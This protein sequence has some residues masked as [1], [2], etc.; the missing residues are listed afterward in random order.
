[1]EN[2]ND[3]EKYT[4]AAAGAL[5]H[6]Q[7]IQNTRFGG[8]GGSDAGLLLRIGRNGMSA[9]NNTDMI[10][11]A[12][13]MGYSMPD[14]FGGNVY[15]RAGHAFEEY[16]AETLQ[17]PAKTKVQ[18][19][20]K[21]E[22]PLARNFKTFAHADFTTRTGRSK[23]TFDVIECKFVQKETDEVAEEYK[24]Q[25]QWYYIMQ[26]NSVT[27]R[28]GTGNVEPF[29]VLT[30]HQMLIERNE[31]IIRDI[32]AG[33]KILDEAI[34]DGWKP[35]PPEKTHVDNTSNSVHAAF[36]TLQKCK[37]E[38]ERL[39][40]EEVQAKAVIESYMKD[41]AC[42]SIFD[43]SGDQVTLTKESSSRSFDSKKLLKDHPE[44]DTDSYYKT[45]TRKGGV[46]FKSST[47]K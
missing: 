22:Q 41:F 33:V 17:V 31:E 10:R 11:L 21:L 14:N 38:K 12:V 1:M 9:I 42:S 25:L 2:Q 19:E 16:V 27:L 45:I 3:F 46:T 35:I 44:F 37:Q 30:D 15:T 40:A 26:A 7:E 47:K 34:S 6:E 18:R 13:M 24:A 28:H 29:E 8:L 43:D 5:E 20:E 39:D 32:M 36:L 4:A 23:R